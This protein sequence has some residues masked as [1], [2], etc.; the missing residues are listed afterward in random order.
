MR[1]RQDVQPARDGFDGFVNSLAA[2]GTSLYVG[3]RFTAY[4]GVAGS[5]ARLAKLDLTTGALDTTFSPPGAA[6]N[7]FDDVVN[8]LA[9]SG[10]SLYVAG[11]F[12]SY[13]GGASTPQRIAKLDATTGAND[14][15]FCPEGMGF[16]GSA[17]AAVVAGT[18]LYVGGSFT[19]YRGV[20]GSASRLAKLD[21][22]TGAPDT[23][24]SPPGPGM[25]G[26]TSPYAFENI[27]AFAVSGSSLLLCGAFAR[28]RGAP[29]PRR[30]AMA[31]NAVTGAP[32]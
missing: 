26:F 4:R 31:V 22:T 13:R 12:T 21:L 6:S 3:G 27:R 14:V 10:T 8:A 16:S 2:I 18:S 9:V 5:A 17:E 28:Y 19:A 11:Q 1:D 30:N 32:Q 25:N 29:T 20:A 23:T 24:F 15:T 7:G